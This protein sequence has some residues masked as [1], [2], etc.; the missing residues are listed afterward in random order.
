VAIA[1]AEAGH[2]EMVD[3]GKHRIS[4]AVDES[5]ALGAISAWQA[6]H[7][8]FREAFAIARGCSFAYDKL[9]AYTATLKEYAKRKGYPVPDSNR[10]IEKAP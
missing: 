1:A 7:R 10:A 3:L 5:R 4:Y 2:G 8:H 6:R 9:G